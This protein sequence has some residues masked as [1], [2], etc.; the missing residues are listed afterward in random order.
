MTN[1][2]F[3]RVRLLGTMLAL[4][5]SRGQLPP[6]P[7]LA[8]VKDLVV[9]GVTSRTLLGN[10]LLNWSAPGD[11]RA[12]AQSY[13]LRYNTCPLDAASFPG[14]TSVSLP[15]PHT[16]GTVETFTVTG[17]EDKTTY[18][19]AL[20][21]I[22]ASGVASGL[23]NVVQ[24]TVPD[25]EPPAVPVLSASQETSDSV[26]FDWNA[27]GDDGKTG[28]AASY[29]LRWAYDNP[30]LCPPACPLTA[31]NF[32][33]GFLV[34]GLPPPKPAGEPESFTVTG[35]PANIFHTRC[36]ALKVTDG[37]GNATLSSSLWVT[38]Q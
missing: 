6:M 12:S 27:V 7:P 37:A 1:D 35:L 13:D 5:C 16:G 23:S 18:C 17:L 34:G 31:E 8:P 10:V 21:S 38:L 28:T 14:A 4:G 19:F 3:R 2:T 24:A 11:S 26:H 29:E 22:N 15:A 36:F 25:A 30:T 32:S 9:V 20:T 33:N